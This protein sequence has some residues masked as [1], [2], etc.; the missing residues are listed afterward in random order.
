MVRGGGNL[1][2]TKMIRPTRLRL[3]TFVACA[4]LVLTYTAVHAAPKSPEASGAAIEA[5]MLEG[6]AIYRETSTK[7]ACCSRDAGI[8]VICPQPPSAG[9]RC[10]V[11][12]YRASLPGMT[13]AP[14]P[15]LGD[16]VMQ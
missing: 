16:L 15:D 13:V 12:P 8:C 6:D 9:N 1:P 2:E 3:L 11:V 4:A 5:C 14:L 10:D 7:F